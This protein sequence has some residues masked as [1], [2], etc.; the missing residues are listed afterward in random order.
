MR[1]QRS[2]QKAFRPF[3]IDNIL[4]GHLPTPLLAL[5][6]LAGIQRRLSSGFKIYCL[7]IYRLYPFTMD[8]VYQLGQ[9]ERKNDQSIGVYGTQHYRLSQFLL[10]STGYLIREQIYVNAKQARY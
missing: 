6:N 5:I 8:T 2:P 4:L 1:N 3:K 10:R 9:M 7:Q